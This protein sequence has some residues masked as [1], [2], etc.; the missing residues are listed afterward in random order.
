MKINVYVGQDKDYKIEFVLHD[1]PTVKLIYNRL[2][3]I[4]NVISNTQVS[5]F[6]D[7]TV[8][9]S[10]LEKVVIELNSLGFPIEYTP[11]DLNRLHINFP[12]NLH[13]YKGNKEIWQTLS[14]FNNLIHE[15]ETTQRG[16]TKLWALSG[17]D[18]GEPLLEESYS[19]FEIPK[20][21]RLYMNYPHVGKHFLELFIDKD[22]ECP[23]EQ[24]VLTHCYNASLLQFFHTDYSFEELEPHLK[25]FHKQVEDKLEYPWGDER[26]AIGYLPIGDMIND[27]EEVKKK[28]ESYGYIHSWECI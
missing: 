22:V 18:A 5:G 11:E 4:N 15:L 14:H 9:K 23:K 27:E 24:I 26:L 13:K 16:R 21:G 6:R 10:D 2:H 8:I 3:Y 28:I 17:V 7:T 25:E 19:L 12:E 20:S 1:N